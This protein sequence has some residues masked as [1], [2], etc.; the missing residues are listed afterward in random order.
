MSELNVRP[1]TACT[2]AVEEQ[3]VGIDLERIVANPLNRKHFD[4][5]RDREMA[6]SLLANGQLEPAIVRPAGDGRYELIA[7]ERRMRGCKLAGLQVLRCIVREMSAE[8]AA[9]QLLISNLERENLT[10]ME[11]AHAFDGLRKLQDEEGRCLYTVERI[12]ER[13]Y[14]RADARKRV[15]RTL[16]LL[17]LPKAMQDA[18]DEGRVGRIVGWLVAR[19][20][21]PGDRE[22]AASEVLKPKFKAEPLTVRETREM[23]AEKYQRSLR[24]VAWDLED[25]ELVEVQDNPATGERLAG[26]ACISC[27]YFAKES[28]HVEVASGAGRGQSGAAGTLGVDAMTCTNVRCFE[29]KLEALWLRAA[30]EIADKEPGIE[31]VP[32]SKG[33]KWFSKEV[34]GA[35]AIDAPVV[36]LADEVPSQGRQRVRWEQALKGTGVP[37]MLACNP[38]GKPVRVA[39]RK[40]AEAAL[41]EAQP[42]LAPAAPE[43]VGGSAQLERIDEEEMAELATEARV[44]GTPL[45]ALVEQRKKV[46]L[47]ER[48][49]EDKRLKL[50]ESEARV[51]A[52]QELQAAM[53]ARGLNVEAVKV[54]WRFCNL[55]GQGDME[56]YLGL[57]NRQ[58]VTLE[59][60]PDV[61]EVSVPGLLAATVVAAIIED[62]RISGIDL[63]TG[64]RELFRSY[65]VDFGAIH[66]RALKAH[67]LADSQRAAAEAEKEKKEKAGRA[68]NSSDPVAWSTAEEAAK[69]E[70]ADALAGQ[71]DKSEAAAKRLYESGKGK[72]TIAKKL[73]LPVHQVGN[74]IVRGGWSR[75]EAQN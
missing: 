23:I 72:R 6:D 69:T 63:A 56:K 53:V 17:A 2:P 9:E 64:V 60:W 35:L 30:R 50:I 67:A 14:G 49:T 28:E 71:E 38:K 20:A 27:P 46:K 59:T 11:E 42:A 15:E 61:D 22:R 39:D 41:R 55:G 24:G 62:L 21:D 70:A 10:A 13:V 47:A 40:L 74:W 33:M 12:A 57:D 3:V 54:L 4:A 26:G 51:E 43:S 31:I 73:G 8:C 34:A 18:I 16:K 5:A 7:G 36:R 1:M 48:K 65:G 68:K 29:L 25:G 19:I 37:V 44:Q 58:E 45:V 75:A 52:L 32:R 66:A